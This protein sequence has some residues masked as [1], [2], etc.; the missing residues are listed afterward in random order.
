MKKD[1]IRLQQIQVRATHGCYENEKVHPQNFIVNITCET[2][3][4][5]D[6]SDLLHHTINYE[7]LRAIVFKAFEQPPLNLIETL[8][9]QIASNILALDKV[10]SVEVRI[11]KPAIWKDALP[12]VEIYRER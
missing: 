3:I 9:N 6:D 1:I 7:N 2:D 11:S 12:E 5:L 10:F 4:E 8:A